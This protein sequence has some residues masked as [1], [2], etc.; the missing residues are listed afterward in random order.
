MQTFIATFLIF[1]VMFPL[2][3][4]GYIVARKKLTG[5]CGGLGKVLGE[6]CMFCEK[7]DDCPSE[8]KSFEV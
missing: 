5:S 3:G 4:I 8:N 7:K 6:E 1:L 2:M